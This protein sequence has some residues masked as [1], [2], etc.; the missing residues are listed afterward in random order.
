MILG[1]EAIGFGCGDNRL[2]KSIVEA[3][4]SGT[5]EEENRKFL[6]RGERLQ[7]ETGLNVFVVDLAPAFMASAAGEIG[8]SK[9]DAIL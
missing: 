1:P 7:G 6:R 5:G 3:Q 2:M 9:I 4:G 8:S